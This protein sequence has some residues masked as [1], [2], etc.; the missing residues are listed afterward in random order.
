[1][2]SFIVKQ[3][4][5]Y[6]SPPGWT[7]LVVG[8]DPRSEAAIRSDKRKGAAAPFTYTLRLPIFDSA[9]YKQVCA[10]ECLQDIKLQISRGAAKLARS[11][12]PQPIIDQ[13]AGWESKITSVSSAAVPIGEPGQ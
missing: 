2:P 5:A 6:Y 10:E 11:G 1:M 3:G 13:I 9:R 8:M 4:Q 12:L 7:S